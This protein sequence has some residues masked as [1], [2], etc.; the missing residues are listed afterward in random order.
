MRGL[1]L[2]LDGIDHCG[3]STQCQL[4]TDWLLSED[5]RVVPCSDPG[6]TSLGWELRQLLLNWD[7]DMSTRCEAMLFM[8]SRAQLVDQVI[9]PAL[10]EGSIV[11]S[12]RFLL[13]NVVYQ[14]HAG[15][16]DPEELWQIG[17]W[18]TG[19]LSPDLTLVLDL[20]L[21]QARARRDQTPD[22]V[23]SRE[24]AFHQRVREGFL[25]EAEKSPEQIKVLD[26][27]QNV[28]T[29]HHAIRQEVAR[30]LESRQ[31]T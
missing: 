12:D 5:H 30:A 14:G 7:H 2:S 23:E 3:K 4:L 13:A 10:D 6:S 1:F 18:G 19:G 20:S 15:L 21:E 29:L 26:A 16:L 11:I 22:R 8:A 28:E 27:S 31:R 9:R 25:A 17:L 24:E